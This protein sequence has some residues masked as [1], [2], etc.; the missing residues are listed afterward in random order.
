MVNF[1]LQLQSANSRTAR[2]PYKPPPPLDWTV[3]QNEKTITS[4]TPSKLSK[5]PCYSNHMTSQRFTL[6]LHRETSHNS[7][8][9]QYFLGAPPSFRTIL[10]STQIT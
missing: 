6:S 2:Y 9:E 7:A 8:C 3:R 1:L 10:F 4:H 5:P